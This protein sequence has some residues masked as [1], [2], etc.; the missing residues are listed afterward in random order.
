MTSGS[1]F[2][3][4]HIWCPVSMG[5]HSSDLPLFLNISFFLNFVSFWLCWVL[6]LC[7]PFSD[8]GKQGLRSSCV[9][10]LLTGVAS[11]VAGRGL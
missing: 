6:L 4:H 11:L 1:I 5:G 2:H 10:S 3:G 7:R 9:C 8:S